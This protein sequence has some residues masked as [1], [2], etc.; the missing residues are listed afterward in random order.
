MTTVDTS[1]AEQTGASHAATVAEAPAAAATGDP[2]QIGLPC[3]IVG[4][5]ALGLVL[6]GYV[7]AAAVGASLPIILAATGFGLAIAAVWAA[8]LGQ[9]A[10]ASVF[11]IFTGFWWSYAVLVLGL[12][13]NWFAI[14]AAA[15]TSTQ[16]L[17]LISWL[18]VI[19]MLT[20]ATLRLPVAFTVLFLLVDL[21]LVLVLMSTLQG[22]AGLGHA[23]G[24]VVLVF[25]AVGVYLYFGSA[26]QATGGPA[27][28][29][30]PAVLH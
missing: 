13:H 19:G 14:T 9:S 3:F 27:L 22:S 6:V 7:P 29:L 30:G 18:V 1:L 12:T 5:V 4:S 17:F 24:I 10:V 28:P 25:A 20:L 26:S 21:A 16:G 8:V 15:A 2:M 23:A 11:G